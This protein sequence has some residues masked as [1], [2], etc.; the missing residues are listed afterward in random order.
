MPM[1]PFTRRQFLKTTATAGAA[2]TLAQF[3]PRL[4]AADSPAAPP[5]RTP[6]WTDKPM[7]WAQLTLV[8]DDPGKF[9]PAFWL[10]YFKRTNSDAVC[11][12]GGGCVAYY[13]T[14]IPFHHRS[15]WLGDRD[16]LGELVAGCRKLGLVVL[17]RTDPHATYDDVEAR[18]RIGSP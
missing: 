18:I 16:V 14:Q 4:A 5:A 17:A 6:S 10:D 1:S 15:P 8:E 12:S 2:V 11:F 3:T 13:P 9:D 7:R